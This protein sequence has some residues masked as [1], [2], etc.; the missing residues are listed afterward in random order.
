MNLRTHTYAIPAVSGLVVFALLVSADYTFRRLTHGAGYG[1]AAYVTD[2]NHRGDH[3]AETAIAVA[4]ALA[5][6]APPPVAPAPE[7]AVAI[8]AAPPPA[9]APQPAAGGTPAPLR[10]AL[11]VNAAM[12][13]PLHVLSSVSLPDLP[14]APAPDALA[15]ALEADPPPAGAVDAEIEL[16]VDEPAQARI[17]C[18]SDQ[19][20]KRCRIGP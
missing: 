6:H 20:F 2:V 16:A 3:A 8:A 17:I 7:A 18:S 4:E 12:A 10:A 9:A 1:F 14:A 15:M 13:L 11:A 5:P 19:G